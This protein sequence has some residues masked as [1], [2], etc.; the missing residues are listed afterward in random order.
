[1]S[2]KLSIIIPVINESAYIGRL[3][4]WITAHASKENIAEIVVVD[5]GST[6]NSLEIIAAFEY[7]SLLNS[8]K[9]R[10]KQLN[11]GASVAKGGI[12]YFLHADSFP[13]KGF[14]EKIL[15]A[16]RE[17]KTGSFRLKFE[18]PNHFLLKIAPW[19][20]QFNYQ[21]FR[22]GDQSLFITQQ[23]FKALGGFDERYI[24][25]EDIELIQRIYR[26]FPF[27]VLDDYVTTSER[28]FNQQG[29]WYLYFHFFMIHLKNWLG[30]TPDNLFRYYSKNIQA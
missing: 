6:D 13:P 21:L 4:S 22:G 20:T 8:P 5:G 25:F 27:V 7:V 1:M 26:L 10:A 19:F 23:Q 29:T 16:V 28:K 24:I 3:L 11:A 2:D 14:D 12:L 17:G 30:A 9:G 18:H 15:Q